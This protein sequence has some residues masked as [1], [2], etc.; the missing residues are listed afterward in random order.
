[1]YHWVRWPRIR[2][3]LSI[4]LGQIDDLEHGTF[5]LCTTGSDD[6]EIS[7]W[8]DS[9][10]GCQGPKPWWWSEVH[11]EIWDPI[12]LAH[13]GGG[14]AK[15]LYDNIKPI[16]WTFCFVF[17]C[18]FMQCN[19]SGQQYIYR[20]QSEHWTSLHR[21]NDITGST[22]TGLGNTNQHAHCLLPMCF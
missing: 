15:I 17:V 2:H 3:V 12:W 20:K 7:V 5:C 19:E 1:M 14:T 18:L 11:V 4:P 13:F 21:D 10:L 6:L 9:W 16:E 22:N 8:S